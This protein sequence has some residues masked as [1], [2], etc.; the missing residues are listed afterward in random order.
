MAKEPAT[1]RARHCAGYARSRVGTSAL[2]CR[3]IAVMSNRLNLA[4]IR[5]AIVACLACKAPM[6][7]KTSS[8][9]DIIDFTTLTKMVTYKC[10]N[11]GRETQRQVTIPAVRAKR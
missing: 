9:A 7:E 8:A 6:Q 10:P 11:C 4:Y 2:S 5:P 1:L 3:F